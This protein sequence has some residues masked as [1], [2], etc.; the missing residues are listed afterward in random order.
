MAKDPVCGM[1]VNEETGVSMSEYNSQTYYFCCPG[2]KD[3][4]DKESEKYLGNETAG[5]RHY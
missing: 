2:C 4:F 3:S 5:G 1:K